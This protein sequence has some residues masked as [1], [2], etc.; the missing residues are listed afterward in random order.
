MNND[1]LKKLQE[2]CEQSQKCSEALLRLSRMLS[3]CMGVAI[4]K[5]S[6][7][8]QDLQSSIGQLLLPATESLAEA[9]GVK[10]DDFWFMVPPKVRHLAANHPKARVRNKNW[11]RMWKIRERYINGV[12]NDST[13]T[14]PH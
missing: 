5:F 7:I 1:E 4:D 13:E 8:V 9:F 10:N 6:F 2:T 14:F 11:N 3:T 12:N